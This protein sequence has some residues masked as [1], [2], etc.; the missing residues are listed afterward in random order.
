[1]RTDDVMPAGVFWS[2]C[3]CSARLRQCRSLRTFKHVWTVE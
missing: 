1:V 2:A 3:Q